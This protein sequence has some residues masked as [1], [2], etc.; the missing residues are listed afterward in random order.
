MKHLQK[1]LSQIFSFIILAIAAVAVILLYQYWLMDLEVEIGLWKQ[2]SMPTNALKGEKPAEEIK[3]GGAAATNPVPEPTNEPE[4]VVLE[5]WID[6]QSY[7]LSAG[8]FEA[9]ARETKE[10]LQVKV[11][12]STK[13]YRTAGSPI[14]REYFDNFV[15]FYI[16]AKDVYNWPFT[17]KG[18]LYPQEEGIRFI[19][20]DEVFWTAQ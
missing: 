17:V 4:Q 10:D 18:M 3:N 5:V 2:V 1:G 19:I 14:N 8:T 20:A 11:N 7:N 9:K 15:E 16:I 12:N 6:I 13:F